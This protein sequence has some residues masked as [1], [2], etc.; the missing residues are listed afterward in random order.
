LEVLKKNQFIQIRVTTAEKQ[1]WQEAAKSAGGSLSEAIRLVM[2][3]KLA[4][5][6]PVQGMPS[7]RRVVEDPPL[8]GVPDRLEVPPKDITPVLK[9]FMDA[10]APG[11]EVLYPKIKEKPKRGRSEMCEHR[12]PPDQYC[13]QGCD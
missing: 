9:E 13:K 3:A 5:S 1:R 12:V 6:Q 11:A 7:E 4:G 8:V 2:N 10:T